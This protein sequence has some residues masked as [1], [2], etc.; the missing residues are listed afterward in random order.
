MWSEQEDLDA[1]E[2][3][4]GAAVQAIAAAKKSDSQELAKLSDLFAPEIIARI[5]ASVLGERYDD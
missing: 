2:R 4:I 3:K 5:A 1:Q